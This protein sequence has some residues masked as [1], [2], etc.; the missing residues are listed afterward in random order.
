VHTPDIIIR[1]RAGI[2]WM[3]SYTEDMNRLLREDRGLPGTCFT[4]E[5]FLKLERTQLF[6]RSWMCIGLSVD[7]AHKG[8][9]FPVSVLGLPLLMVRDGGQLRVFHNVCRH[10][11]AILVETVARAGPRIVCPYH[12]WGYRLNGELATTPHWEVLDHTSAKVWKPTRS[13]CERCVARSGRGTF[14]QSVR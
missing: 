9:L 3:S 8:D 13:D 10:R 6:E 11:G 2:L 5:S 12:G 14:R 1:F 4:D 7:V